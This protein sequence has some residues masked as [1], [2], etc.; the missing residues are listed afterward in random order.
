V[1]AVVEYLLEIVNKYEDND[2]INIDIPFEY[3]P[4]KFRKYFKD[5]FGNIMK[6]S[7]V[8]ILKMEEIDRIKY[9]NRETKTK[10]NEYIKLEEILF[11]FGMRDYLDRRA[12]KRGI[13]IGFNEKKQPENKNSFP[14]EYVGTSR[15][16]KKRL[17][18][19]KHQGLTFSLIFIGR[20]REHIE[21]ILINLFL[22]SKNT[23]GII[24]ERKSKHF[25]TIWFLEK[26]NG[27]W[28]LSKKT[29][30]SGEWHWEEEEYIYDSSDFIKRQEKIEDE[31]I[32]GCHY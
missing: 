10:E 32:G 11:S 13:Y 8:N 16:M 20:R 19:H 17:T 4:S 29:D 30:P 21:K 31:L 12:D 27:R 15:N 28:C 6:T 9:D 18:G 1:I 25:R 26:N 5:Y 22:P 14:I 24:P 2:Y 3:S 7:T 23:A